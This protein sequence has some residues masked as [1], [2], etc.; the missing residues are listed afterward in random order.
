MEAAIQLISGQVQGCR[1]IRSSSVF[2]PKQLKLS[3]KN[4]L[5]NVLNVLKCIVLLPRW[6]STLISSLDPI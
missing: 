5:S 2:M 6:Y 1:G 4:V 3:I